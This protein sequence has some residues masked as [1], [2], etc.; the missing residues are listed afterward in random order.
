MAQRFG[1][2]AAD[3][4]VLGFFLAD[5]GF[6]FG[7][8]ARQ[9]ELVAED[10]GQ[11]FQR[12]IDFENVLHRDRCRPGLCRPLVCRAAAGDGLADFAL[13][14][15][16]AAGA[17]FA[18]AE[19]RHVELRQGNADQIAPFAAD[20]F[21]MRNVL[22]QVLADFSADNLAKATMIVV[23]VEDAWLSRKRVG[24]LNCCGMVSGTYC[25]ASPRAKMLAT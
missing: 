12:D 8:D 16:G 11:F 19:M 2:G 7:L 14:L 22:T 20:H 25:L 15:P 4:V 10:G 13:A 3:A 23:D 5:V 9:L 6:A 17:V 18:V 21:A 24:L 1:A